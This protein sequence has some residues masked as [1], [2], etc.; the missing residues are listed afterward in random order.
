M[1]LDHDRPA[2][3]SSIGETLRVGHGE[4]AGYGGGVLLPGLAQEAVGLPALACKVHYVL[5]GSP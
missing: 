4:E 3:S 1:A 2:G 5:F